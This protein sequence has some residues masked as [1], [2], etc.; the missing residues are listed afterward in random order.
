MK[1]VDLLNPFQTMLI[2]IGALPTAYIE[3]MSYYEGLTYLV[4]YLTNNVIPAVNNNGEV[5]KELQDKYVEL[6]EYV[7]NY[8]SD[9]NIQ[10]EINN[11]LD[12]MAAEGELTSLILDYLQM[13]GLIMFDTTDDM[14]AAENL[15]EGSFTKTLGKLIYSD[16]LGA[17]YKVRLKDVAD[18]PDDYD[19]VELT[20]YPTLIAERIVTFEES[21][22]ND[23]YS[24][25]GNLTE[26]TT[27]EKTS[28]V[29]AVNEVVGDI[30]DLSSLT[31][32]E[33]S[34]IVG[35]VN[36]VNQWNK[37]N[38]TVSHQAYRSTSDTDTAQIT[39]GKFKPSTSTFTATS[40][41]LS[42]AYCNILGAT[43]T[44]GSIGKLYG[45][46]R[47]DCN[48]TLSDTN[49]YPCLRLRCEDFGINVPDEGYNIWAAGNAYTDGLFSCGS[50]YI[51]SDGYIYVYTNTN[52][53]L[54]N[55]LLTMVLNPCIYFWTSFGDTPD[56]E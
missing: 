12:E 44:D 53:T 36:E 14:K 35:A 47:V 52:I 26:L 25:V 9:L 4:N 45:M 24:K 2:T 38:L 11:K 1:K 41:G 8:F 37:F 29:S 27:T 13:N 48:Y 7:N 23:I 30:G 3:S 16:G 28:V 21:D 32:S 19:L 15:I 56:N 39:L 50:L 10:N 31:T 33:K 43:N 17:Y 34:S 40:S 6:V 51:G 5:V 22:I 54:S 20:N 18:V 55:K 42:N 46:L 49:G